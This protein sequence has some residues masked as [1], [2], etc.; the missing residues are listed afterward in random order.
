MTF[1]KRIAHGLERRLKKAIM[2]YVLGGDQVYC[3]IC[4]KS[5]ITFLPFGLMPQSKRANAQCPN[6]FSLE[7]TRLYWLFLKSI[8]GFFDCR[9]NILHVAPESSLFSEFSRTRHFRYF[10]IDRFEVGYSYPKGTINMDVTSLA[11]E[12]NYFDFILCSHVLEHVE[13]D[14]TAMRELYRVL[15][16][17]GLGI[18]QVPV[19]YRRE[20]THEDP[21][22]RTQDG[23]R[24]AFGQYDHV[25]T[26]GTDYK[27][28]LQAAGFVVS[29]LDVAANYTRYERFRFGLGDEEQLYIVRKT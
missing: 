1:I 14:V 18:I 21:L 9:K 11:F 27:L 4:S 6:C 20:I 24:E 5:F 19:D 16:V 28:R 22:I 12:D 7:R 13:D 15:K 23:R 10:P 2:P 8:D 26:Y 29:V 3:V 17:D 25:R